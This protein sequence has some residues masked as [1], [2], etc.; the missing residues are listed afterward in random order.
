MSALAFG[1]RRVTTRP[2]GRRAALLVLCGAFLM[3]ILDTTIVNVALPTI[4]TALHFSQSSVAWV[5][6][7]YVVAFGGLL[8]LAGRLGDVIGRERVF[9]AGITV[10]T[11]ASAA[12]AGLP[13]TP[14]RRG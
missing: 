6:D 4:R 1:S 8:L 11:A 12:C 13:T 10:F 14:T 3:V 2:L 7:A 5:V 9:T